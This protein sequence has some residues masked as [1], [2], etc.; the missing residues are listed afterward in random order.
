MSSTDLLTTQEAAAL[1]GISE[2][3]VRQLIADKLLPA[4][5]LRREWAIRRA[6]L[7]TFRAQ[8]RQPGRPTGWRKSPPEST[9]RD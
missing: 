6:D 7:D 1:L 9:P 5:H 2:R 4:T 3:R 8:P